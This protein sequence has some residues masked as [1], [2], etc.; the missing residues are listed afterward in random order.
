VIVI[1]SEK[2]TP[3]RA[4]Y[5]ALCTLLVCYVMWYAGTLAIER[6]K[7]ATLYLGLS[8][9]ILFLHS[10][11]GRN[12][13]FGLK[14]PLLNK[15]LSSIFI[16]LAAMSGVYFFIEYY[17]IIYYRMGWGNIYDLMFGTIALI[18]VL[19]CCRKDVEKWLVILALAFMVYAV[20][21]PYIPTPLLRHGGL[22]IPALLRSLSS[23]IPIGIFGLLTQIAFTWISAFV[24]LASFLRALGGYDTLFNL[25][26]YMVE[27]SP[28]LVPQTGVIMSA[29]F[30]MFSGSAPANVAGTGIFTIPMN[31]RAGV[32][33]KFAAAI[34]SVAS[35][36]GLIVPPV[37]GAAAFI[38]AALLGVPYIY[39]CAIAVIPCII[40]YLTTSIGVFCVT[41]RYLDL[42]KAWALVKE[43]PPVRAI[44]FVR[45]GLPFFSALAILIFLMAYY[46]LDPLLACFFTLMFYLPF[47]FVYNYFVVFRR[48]SSGGFKAYLVDLARRLRTSIEEG[49]SLAASAGVMLATINIIT[50]ILTVTGSALKWSMALTHLVGYNLALLVLVAWLITTFLGFGVSATGVYVIAI[51]VLLTP[52]G[53]FVHQGVLSG[54]IIV[55]FFVFWVAVLSA[56]TPPVAIACA[57]AAKIAQESFGTVS[58]ESLKLGFPLFLLCLSFF[59]WQ[60]LLVWTPMTPVA[61]L[62]LIISSVSMPIAIY[63]MPSLEE[64]VH[65]KILRY[66]VRALLGALSF[67]LF[68]LKPLLPLY[69]EYVMAAVAGGI[70]F[71]LIALEVRTFKRQL[72]AIGWTR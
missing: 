8:C 54:H 21:G 49:A 16:A 29:L 42:Q 17:N 5:I 3:L 10:F 33:A 43:T 41:R 61:A 64:V 44:D 39:V 9:I 50:G 25:A 66:F 53:Y 70:S 71:A 56:I 67:T 15:A 27:R 30:G 18:L 32:P 68:I 11:M 60:D 65:S 69:I 28:Y 52:F 62:I 48:A 22:S 46:R 47:A 14:S 58:W 72:K 59:T 7:A 51:S 6:E 19:E 36:G 23:D 2:I 13:V 38:M 55:H 37:M 57:T 63:G 26:R 4:S 40:Y 24:I 34:E 31:K 20:I 12:H 35:S 45:T 1:T